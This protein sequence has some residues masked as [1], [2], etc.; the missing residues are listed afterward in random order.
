M[1]NTQARRILRVE[2]VAEPQAHIRAVLLVAVNSMISS[3]NNTHRLP[4]ASGIRIRGLTIDKVVRTTTIIHFVSFFSEKLKRKLRL[5]DKGI[6]SQFAES[7]GA[8]LH[9][10][11]AR[12]GS[13]GNRRVFRNSYGSAARGKKF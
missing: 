12:A 7:H 10:Y 13:W 9:Q 4:I 6:C 8:F 2:P 5:Q 11:A 1:Y 3:Y